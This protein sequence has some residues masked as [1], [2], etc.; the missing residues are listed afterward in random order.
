MTEEPTPCKRHILMRILQFEFCF[1][2]EKLFF[3]PDV[4][5]AFFV[6]RG[7]CRNSSVFVVI[8][9]GLYWHDFVPP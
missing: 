7:F 8:L 2:P 4:F 5:V 3:V 9:R 6:I 1:K